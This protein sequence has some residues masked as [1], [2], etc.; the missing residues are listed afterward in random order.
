M[1][2]TIKL[3]NTEQNI[4]TSISG[5]TTKIQKIIDTTYRHNTESDYTEKI[6]DLNKSFSYNSNHNYYWSEPEQSLLYG[7]PLYEQASPSQRLI[8]NH[9]HW[10]INYNYISDSETETVIFNQVTA[11]VFEAIGGYQNLVN[12]LAV[13]TEQEHYHINTFRKIGLMTANAVIGRKGLNALLKWNS[14]KL[15]LGRNSLATYEYYILRSLA[16]RMFQSQKPQYS[17][18]LYELEQQNQFI[19]KAPTTGMLGRSL[20]LPLQSF[21]SFNWGSGSPFMA[22]QFY[23][24]R[25][26]ANLYLKNMEHSIVKYFRKLERKN[27]FIPTPTAVSYYHFLDESFHTTISQLLAKDLYKNFTKPTLYEKSVANLVIYLMQ[28][29]TLGGIS[30]VLPYRYFADDYTIMELIYRLLQTPVFGMSSQD[31]LY[32]LNQ[33]L[34]SEHEGFYLASKNRQ[35]LLKELRRFF[36]DVDYLWP[37]NREMRVMAARG[38]ISEAIANNSKTFR[39]FSH[40]VIS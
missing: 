22:C 35:R 33:C 2:T 14:Y 29:G 26:I 23:A 34:C 5:K 40:S 28:C 25:I 27:E 4:A 8:L 36:A 10:F 18:Y 9:L 13:E 39:Q 6:V 31:A 1:T 37:V 38:A 21:F 30:G 32:W 7:T 11:S 3:P 15:A 20:D 17:R 12:E 24:I 16:N 19:I